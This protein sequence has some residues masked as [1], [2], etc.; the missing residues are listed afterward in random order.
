V[1]RDVRCHRL[2]HIPQAVFMTLLVG[3]VFSIVDTD[4][5]VE[6][7]RHHGHFMA[8]KVADCGNLSL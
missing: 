5:L 7:D 2:G 1:S 4:Y 6:I 8:T 3:M